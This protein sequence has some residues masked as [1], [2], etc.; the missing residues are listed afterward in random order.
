MGRHAEA[1]PLYRRALDWREAAYGP[2]HPATLNSAGNLGVFYRD[3]GRVTDA[4]P[5]L[6][7]AQQ[8]CALELS[9]QP[10]STALPLAP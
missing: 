8:A 9:R 3:V 5:L 4:E 7:R 2:T 10:S 6:Q 1:E